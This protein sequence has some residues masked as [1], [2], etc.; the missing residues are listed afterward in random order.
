MEHVHRGT[1]ATVYSFDGDYEFIE[2]SIRKARTF[3]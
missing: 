1:I 3:K 2:A